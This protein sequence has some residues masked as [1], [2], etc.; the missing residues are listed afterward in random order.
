M[1]KMK[2]MCEAV[3]IYLKY[4]DKPVGKVKFSEYVL[5]QLKQRPG[6]T[7]EE[8]EKIKERLEK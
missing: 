1:M 8:F 4:K 6:M 2:M 3:P 5:S 7:V